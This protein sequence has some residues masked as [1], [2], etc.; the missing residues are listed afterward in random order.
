MCSHVAIGCF[1]LILTFPINPILSTLLILVLPPFTLIWQ[2]YYHISIPP[3]I[4]KKGLGF[5]SSYGN[6]WFVEH[7]LR[8]ISIALANIWRLQCQP[9]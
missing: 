5:K 2:F 9:L 6:K 7:P 4:L 8:K 1:F 3:W